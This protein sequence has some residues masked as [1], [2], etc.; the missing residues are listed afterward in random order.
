MMPLVDAAEP[1]PPAMI[2]HG[3]PMFKYK[4]IGQHF[5]IKEG[6]LTPLLE[7][8]SASS[9]MKL[10]GKTYVRAVDKKQWFDQFVI[11]QDGETVLDAALVKY[12]PNTMRV[13][14]DGQPLNMFE[15]ALD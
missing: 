4:G 6:E 7:W 2:V 15:G 13:L 10:L 3:D 5:W 11:T 1:P 8:K 14:L 9:T 12:G